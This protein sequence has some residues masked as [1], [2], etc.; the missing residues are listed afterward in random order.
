MND[1]DARRDDWQRPHPSRLSPTDPLFDEIVRRHDAAVASRVPTYVD[2][3]S[4]FSV[5]TAPFLARR[6]TCCASGCRHCP[7]V[8]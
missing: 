4:G 3:S 5:F 8:I 1:S 6:D 2:P 7:Y